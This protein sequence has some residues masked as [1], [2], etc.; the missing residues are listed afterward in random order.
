MNMC[1]FQIPSD[2]TELEQTVT[3]GTLSH[4]EQDSYLP[5]AACE[6]TVGRPS[7]EV[8]KQLKLNGVISDKIVGPISH[9]YFNLRWL[10]EERKR[11]LPTSVPAHC[12]Q[13]CNCESSLDPSTDCQNQCRSKRILCLWHSTI[14]SCSSQCCWQG[15]H[16]IFEWHKS[17]NAREIK[18]NPTHIHKV[19]QHI[20]PVPVKTLA[21]PSTQKSH[22]QPSQWLCSKYYCC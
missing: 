13:Y 3:D 1:G 16:L 5:W 18:S 6:C 15:M 2:T 14:N 19:Q 4:A 10:L 21:L 11:K 9:P 8:W 17:D 7:E 22:A 12:L 20:S